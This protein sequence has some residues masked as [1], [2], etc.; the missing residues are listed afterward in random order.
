MEKTTYTGTLTV[1]ECYKC[2]MDF[3][4]TVELCQ[5]RRDDHEVFW[6][7]NGHRQHFSGKSEEEKL[8]RQ[9]QATQDEANYQA[10]RARQANE[11]AASL[12]K[13]R[14]AYKGHLKRTKKRI[15]AGV[16]PCCNRT[17]QN[18]GKHMSGQHPDYS[19]KKRDA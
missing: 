9:L 18:L 5:A 19:G 15:A 11:R 13:S 3:G 16:C 7:P 6:C 2:H 4:M 14:N 12:D 8:R 17:F 1:I 10:E